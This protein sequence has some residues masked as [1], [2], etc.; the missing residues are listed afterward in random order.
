MGGTQSVLSNTWKLRRTEKMHFFPPLE[1]FSGFPLLPLIFIFSHFSIWILLG[2]NRLSGCWRHLYIITY[3]RAYP[4][5]LF[6]NDLPRLNTYANHAFPFRSNLSLTLSA[7]FF[8]ITL[9]TFEHTMYLFLLLIVFLPS[10]ECELLEDRDF[11]CDFFTDRL[12]LRTVPG[13]ASIFNRYLLN[14]WFWPY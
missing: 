5:P 6:W 12:T 2:R 4:Y 1:S 11:L 14:E 7:F 10:Q 3:A 9:V 13:T 8:S